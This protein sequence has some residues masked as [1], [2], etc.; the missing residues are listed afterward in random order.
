MLLS[1]LHFN[2]FFYRFTFPVFP[3]ISNL[4]FDILLKISKVFFLLFWFTSIN[5]YRHLNLLNYF[6]MFK[7]ALGSSNLIKTLGQIVMDILFTDRKMT[8]QTTCWD[9]ICVCVPQWTYQHLPLTTHVH[10][11]WQRAL[12]RTSKRV[13]SNVQDID[14]LNEHMHITRQ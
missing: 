1:S 6:Y 9:M 5:V 12:Y 4:L 10:A 2:I 14:T 11:G 13:G 3:V 7:T 8:K